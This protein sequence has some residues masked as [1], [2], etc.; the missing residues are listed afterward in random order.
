LPD[1]VERTDG[2]PAHA[3]NPPSTT[4]SALKIVGAHHVSAP[5]VSGIATPTAIVPNPTIVTRIP[6]ARFMPMA[7]V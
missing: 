7:E 3:T 6:I 5:D 2:H 1:Q 4:I